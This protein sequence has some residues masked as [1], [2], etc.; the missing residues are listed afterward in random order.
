[1]PLVAFFS[2]TEGGRRG[3]AHL[4]RENGPQ[5]MAGRQAKPLYS[6]VFITSGLPCSS[7]T[8]RG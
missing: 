7:V 6:R 4:P 3:K 2:A 8:G 5:Q 1:M